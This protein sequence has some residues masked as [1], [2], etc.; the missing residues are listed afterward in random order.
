MPRT[1]IFSDTFKILNMNRLIE[2]EKLIQKQGNPI[3]L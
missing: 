2:T 1:M 3:V